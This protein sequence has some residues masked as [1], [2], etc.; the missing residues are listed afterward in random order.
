VYQKLRKLVFFLGICNSIRGEYKVR[1]YLEKMVLIGN[2]CLGEVED[3]I[4]LIL[5]V[6]EHV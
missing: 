1:E 3:C 2:T 5:L 4:L 6:L